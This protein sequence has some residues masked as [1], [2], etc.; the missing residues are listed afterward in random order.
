MQKD[1]PKEQ[2]LCAAHLN[3]QNKHEQEKDDDDFEDPLA[4]V[5]MSAETYRRH[6]KTIWKA[7]CAEADKSDPPRIVKPGNG[8]PFACAKNVRLYLRNAGSGHSVVRGYKMVCLPPSPIVQFTFKAIGHLVVRTPDGKFVDPTLHYSQFKKDEP[9][10]FVPSS[11]MHADLT[12]KQLVSGA[13]LFNSVSRGDA[14]IVNNIARM[15]AC[16]SRFLQRNNVES[17]ESFPTVPR[18]HLEPLPYFDDW[19]DVSSISSRSNSHED[20]QDAALAF[21]SRYIVAREEEADDPELEDMCCCGYVPI[22]GLEDSRFES[23]HNMHLPSTPEF[24]NFHK[25]RKQKDAPYLPPAVEMKKYL[26]FYTQ[27]EEEFVMRLARIEE[28]ISQEYDLRE[29]RGR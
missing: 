1:G 28:K 22:E 26:E 14:R 7:L 17:P 18:I 20:Y 21:G 15:H 12:D 25:A 3:Q 5:I 13:Y 29:Q 27:M 6:K 16:V 24:L 11:R 2:A 9:Y 10:I 23:E 19:I 8:C 4:D